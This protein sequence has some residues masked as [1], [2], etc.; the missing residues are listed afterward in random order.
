MTNK[1]HYFIVDTCLDVT[2]Y[3]NV[4]CSFSQIHSHHLSGTAQLLA[5]NPV[6]GA[7]LLHALVYIVPSSIYDGKY[8]T[9]FSPLSFASRVPPLNSSSTADTFLPLPNP[10]L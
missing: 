5:F 2:C 9:T 10:H 1:A 3:P 8:T 7:S 6:R 4:G